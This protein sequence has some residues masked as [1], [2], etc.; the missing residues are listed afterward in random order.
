MSNNMN[1]VDPNEFITLLEKGRR[2]ALDM[3]RH[4]PSARDRVIKAFGL[5]Y[6][7]ARYP[8]LYGIDK[9]PIYDEPPGSNLS[10]PSNLSNL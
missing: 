2:R 6:V 9:P 1:Q 7:K 10:N 8:E 3:L 4:N 5:D